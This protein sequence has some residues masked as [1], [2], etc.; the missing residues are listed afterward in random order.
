MGKINIYFSGLLIILASAIFVCAQSSPQSDDEPDYI[1]PSRPTVSNPAEFQRSGVLQ[2]EFGYNG[3]FKS[4]DYKSQQDAPLSLRFAAGRRLLIELD[5]DNP[6]SQT[7]KTGFRQTGA[8]DTMLGAQIV[9]QPQTESRPGIAFAY[10]VKLPTASAD[11]NLGTGR[12]DSN[13]VGLFSKTLGA[14]TVDFNATYLLAGRT[15]SKGRVSSGQA[16]LAVSQS[17][18]KK[19]ALQGEISGYSRSDR[20]TGAMFGLGAVSYQISKKVSLDGGVKFG[21]TSDA[22]RVGIVAGITVGVAD[23]YKKRH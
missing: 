14:T 10:F 4:A 2:L 16:A 17:I 7:D 20:Q 13:F 1:V 6:Y 15:G 23:L 18:T 3:N 5:L 9:L 21:L 12:V 11:K 22:P 8:G 19:A